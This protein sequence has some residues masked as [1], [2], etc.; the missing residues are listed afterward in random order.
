[1]CCQD[2][3]LQCIQSRR[4]TALITP[5]HICL[6][7]VHLAGLGVD[8]W[9]VWG[10][11]ESW[12]PDNGLLKTLF[13]QQG[14]Q[15]EAVF[16]SHPYW[17]DTIIFDL[18]AVVNFSWMNRARVWFLKRGRVMGWFCHTPLKAGSVYVTVTD[19]LT[20]PCW[21]AQWSP[22]RWA[23]PT[24]KF[25]IYSECFQICTSVRESYWLSGPL[26]SITRLQKYLL[27]SHWSGWEW[28]FWGCTVFPFVP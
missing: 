27:S 2:R 5:P 7:W 16:L 28:P 18:T 17:N 9:W 3:H 22:L 1:M 8:G 25:V 10:H 24:S 26:W 11:P 15:G 20:D 4:V 12:Q 21:S 23:L 13:L 6:W 19:L 14:P